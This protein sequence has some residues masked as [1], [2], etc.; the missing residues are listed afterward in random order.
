MYEDNAHKPEYVAHAKP[1]I[2]IYR[3]RGTMG[4]N[5][6]SQ[7]HANVCEDYCITQT[8]SVSMLLQL[9]NLM[10]TESQIQINT[11]KQ[12][13]SPHQQQFSFHHNK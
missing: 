1:K 7:L 10:C 8:G 11:Y 2:S 6:D 9:H 12:M 5:E 4:S 3:L 13:G